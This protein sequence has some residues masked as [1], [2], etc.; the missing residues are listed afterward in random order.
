MS[1]VSADTLAKAID[2]ILHG[3]LVEKH[4][5]FLET[6]ELQIGLR[7]YDPLKDKRFA[8]TVRLPNPVRP[9]TTILVLGTYADCARATASGIE[10]RDLEFLRALNR[11]KKRIKQMHKHFDVVLASSAI[12]RTIPRLLGPTLS[13][14]RKFP[15]VLGPEDDLDAKAMEL[16]CQVKFSLKKVLGMGTAV[17]HV[18]LTKDELRHNCHVA[19]NFLVAL[20]KKN[21]GNVKTLHLKSTMGHP[22]LLYKSGGGGGHPSNSR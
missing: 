6:V 21:W 2:Y 8:G 11:N 20:L 1:R 13:K 7:D 18:N 17:G 4:R 10:S 14:A 12:I 3:A 19:I 15:T 5:N 16:K 22:F 9:R